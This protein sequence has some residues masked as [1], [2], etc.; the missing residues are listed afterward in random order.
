MVLSPSEVVRMAKILD[1]SLYLV[2][3][4]RSTWRSVFLSFPGLQRFYHLFH[5]ISNRLRER[6]G[7]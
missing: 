7:G 2:T 6:G 1:R 3:L 5:W 4:S